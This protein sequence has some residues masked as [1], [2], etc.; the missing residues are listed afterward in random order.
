MAPGNLEE[1]IGDLAGQIKSL[2]PTLE[3][4]RDRIDEMATN[5]ATANVNIDQLWREIKALKQSERDREDDTKQQ[6]SE[7][8]RRWWS[9]ILSL[10]SAI[11]GG[12]VSLG[13]RSIVS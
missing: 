2:A 10:I 3:Y 12:L 9:V 6:R 13:I 1:K 4:L 5:I 7:G 8:G 11:I